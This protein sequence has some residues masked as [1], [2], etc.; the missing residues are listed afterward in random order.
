MMSRFLSRKNIVVFLLVIM[1]S[2][3]AVFSHFEEK[4]KASY[5]KE[6]DK[7]EP[8]VSLENNEEWVFG[9]WN[10]ETVFANPGS[11]ISVSD[12]GSSITLIGEEES[13]D[14][15]EIDVV[16]SGNYVGGTSNVMLSSWSL[17]YMLPPQLFTSD[18][19]DYQFIYDIGANRLFI[20][21]YDIVVG[22]VSFGDIIFCDEGDVSCYEYTGP[23]FA[24]YYDE[25]IGVYHTDAGFDDGTVQDAGYTFSYT[26][27]YSLLPSEIDKNAKNSFNILF[28]GYDPDT[29][30]TNTVELAT[31]TSNSDIS[32]PDLPFSLDNIYSEEQIIYNSWQD[33]WGINGSEYDYYIE[34]TLGGYIEYSGEYN[35]QFNATAPNGD[36]ILYSA[37]GINFVDTSLTEFNSSNNCSA[38]PFTRDT[39]GCKIIVGYNVEDSLDTAVSISVNGTT[40]VDSLSTTLEWFYT[41]TNQV[42]IDYPTGENKEYVQTLVSD[43]AGVGAINKI[44][45]NKDVVFNWKVEPTA[46]NSTNTNS[47]SV[48]A[49][50][51]FKFSS[52]GTVPYTF[53]LET[54]GGTVDSSYNSVVNPYNLNGN[55]YYYKSFYLIDD[56][57]YDYVL[58]SSNNA[59]VLGESNLNTYTGKYVYVKIN[60][61]SYEFIGAISKMSDGKISYLAND[62]RTIN[63]S[64]VT[65]SNPV[66]LPENVTDIKITYVGTKAAVYIGLGFE[67]VLNSSSDLN[68]KISSLVEN[69]SD[70]VLKNNVQLT[71][72]DDVDSSKISGT[73]LTSAYETATYSG[74]ISNVNDRVTDSNGVK[75]DSITYTDYIYEQVDYSA[76][77][78]SDALE[79]LS[80]QED[81]VFYELLPIGASL[82]GE[83][84][85]KTYGN[86][87]TILATVSST[88][89]YN[90]TGRTMLKVEVN[91]DDTNYYEGSDFIQSGY[92]LT[93]DILY[94]FLSNQS[95]GNNLVKDMAYYGNELTNGYK[96]ANDASDLS[97]SDNSVKKLFASINGNN[98]INNAIFNTLSTEVDSVSF[99]IGSYN[100]Q[101]RND[102]ETIYSTNTS[103]VEGQKYKYRLQYV[104]ASDLEEITNLVFVDKLE[105]NYGNN[106]YFKGYFVSVDTSYLE[107]LGVSPVV[108]YSTLTDLD[109]SNVDLT[110]SSVWSITKPTDVSKIQAIAVSCGNYVFKG[111]DDVAPMIDINM[112]ASNAYDDNTSKS[113]YN[114]SFIQYNNVGYASTKTMSSSGTVVKLNEAEV[115]LI[116]K[117]SK[118]NGGTESNP[119]IVDSSFDYII[120]LT[121]NSDDY[122]QSNLEVKITLPKGLTTDINEITHKSNKTNGVVGTYS[123]DEQN[124]VLSYS[125]SKLLIGEEKEIAIPVDIDFNSLGVESTFV[126][127]VKLVK[128]SNNVYDG[129]EVKLYNRL[130]V[131]TIEYTKYVDTADTD[132]FSDVATVII[133]KGETYKYRVSINNTSVIDGKNI[134]V[135][136]NVP[137]GLTVLESS[138][139]NNGVY[140]SSNN[141]ITWNV[142]SLNANTSLDLDYEVSVSNDIVLGT[143]Y[144]SSAHIK[145][146]N[147]I[148]NSLMLYDDDTNMVGTLYQIIS[149]IKVKNN[150]SGALADLNKEFT[151]TFEFN[152]D[153]SHAGSYDILNKD[154][155]LVDT[156][157][158]DKNGSGKY[159]S[160]LKASELLEFR[161]LPN[162]IVYSIKQEF[163]KG[164]ETTSDDGVV[165]GETILITGITDEEKNISYTINNSY[166]VSTTASISAKVTYDKTITADMFALS[167]VDE[168]NGSK[169]IYSDTNGIV[170]FD[171]ITY[172]NVVGTFKYTISQ[173]NT[174]VNKVSYDTNSYTAVVNVTNDGKG[175]LTATVKYY[176]KNNE[177]VN[178]M[179]FNNVYVP[180]GLIINNVNTSDYVDENK[181]F[182]YKLEITDSINSKGTYKIVDKDNKEIGEL[183]IDESGYALYEFIL[184]SDEKITILDLPENTN[185]LVT[186]GL[187]DYYTSNV[188]DLTYTVD[189][190]NNVISHNG[191]VLDKTIQINFN[192]NYVTSATYT[193]STSVILL[194]KELENEEFTFIIKDVSPGLTNGYMEYT[195]NDIEGNVL[196]STINYNRP[197]TYVY[198]ISQVKGDSN[199]IFYDISKSILTVVLT[200]N[201]DNTMTLVSSLYEYENGKDYFENKYSVEPIVPEENVNNN[202]NSNKNPNTSPGVKRIMIIVGMI[203][204]VIFLFRVEKSMRKKRLS[205]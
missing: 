96:S 49:F 13:L 195:S 65:E 161:L 48:K 140:D 173:V 22:Y 165:D 189:T 101:T 107:N 177:E 40:D 172:D 133:E 24:D 32:A 79:F 152:G 178:E 56:I 125:L 28:E 19:T 78:S 200:D 137:E 199:H 106:K 93:F 186:Q 53:S 193:P 174:N 171:T 81:V 176:N 89:N 75:Y 160:T 66:I 138:I 35:L 70:V 84:V 154:G 94:S 127:S 59:Y 103:V 114:N 58:N 139:N 150:V 148:D 201:G 141:T 134:E 83:V 168:N 74:S 17:Y 4:S 25:L 57:E 37:D 196:F 5:S 108:Y 46:N 72:G 136:D 120:S 64:D 126:A 9:N 38:S 90:G 197:G 112:L 194:E 68:S 20:Y 61:G 44:E 18:A 92:T 60:D 10:I 181:E 170:N 175:V 147:P 188:S 203:L 159:T 71:I 6:V 145:V 80:I 164:Y 91:G 113:A 115:N 95:Y 41:L 110:D 76:G 21:E 204:F 99:T 63:N 15:S 185:Y 190:T 52:E 191:V 105:G 158:L 73:Y 116:A 51:L 34:Y 205:V 16:V 146:V 163:E 169:T 187:V 143:L 67:S 26:L 130:A 97:F 29:D 102:L 132:G 123:Y 47:S 42:A 184:K 183:T 1:L 180:N 135:V 109:L 3:F 86:E 153:S 151:Y 121:N 117:T 131:P 122:D 98:T 128:L 104:F 100:K 39:V 54:V 118:G 157:V 124:N 23:F 50:N 162:G 12:D 167:I 27:T 36:L 33:A 30:S 31:M 8:L 202:S 129:D 192:N 7:V 119:E 77:D 14:A 2:A 43:D 87:N 179:V 62:S 198:E 144:K 11:N 69:G 182:N 166:S 156:L 111:S 85:V 55:E 142:T 149:N 155:K 88:E 45:N 82:D